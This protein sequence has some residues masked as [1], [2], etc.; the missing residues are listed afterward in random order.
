LATS[1]L[2]YIVE[3]ALKKAMLNRKNVLFYK[4]AE[5]FRGRRSVHQ[6]DPPL[7]LAAMVDET[8]IANVRPS[9]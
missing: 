6:P 9:N 3:G 8:D 7:Q 4:D 5:W 1:A 2:V